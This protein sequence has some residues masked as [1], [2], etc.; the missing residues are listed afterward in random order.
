MSSKLGASSTVFL[1]RAISFN[2]CHP[3]RS[4]CFAKRSIHGVEGPH[5]RG[6]FL[7][8]CK[9][10]SPLSL[11]VFALCQ[12]RSREFSQRPLIASPAN[13]IC[14]PHVSARSSHRGFTD[15]IKAIFF[16]LLVVHQPVAMIF[17]GKSLDL[18]P[19]VLHRS[20]VDAVRHPDVKRP[21]PATNDVGVVSVF[22]HS[23]PPPS[24][25]STALR[26]DPTYQLSS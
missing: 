9:A 4:E 10:F 24:V 3:E 7:R 1:R 6:Q 17:P 20:P 16:D 5:A 2:N 21:R 22:L 12:T 26:D 14:A 15:S 19:L 13:S 18:S 25:I 23:N 8:R 11:R